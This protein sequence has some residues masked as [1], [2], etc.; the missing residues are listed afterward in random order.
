MVIL[1]WTS[2]HI[3]SN[4]SVFV[5]SFYIIFVIERFRYGRKW[6]RPLVVRGVGNGGVITSGAFAVLA[7]Q[8]AHGGEGVGH[9]LDFAFVF[10]RGK[11]HTT[12]IS[13]VLLKQ[14]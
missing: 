7:Q 14:K 3:R 13:R 1:V 6:L 10:P 9:T 2:D 8:A 12:V 4:F 5:Y 11:F